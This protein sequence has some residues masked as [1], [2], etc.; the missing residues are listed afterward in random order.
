MRERDVGRKCA[1]G[2]DIHVYNKKYKNL[3][4]KSL[5]FILYNISILTCRPWQNRSQCSQSRSELAKNGSGTINAFH[6][7]GGGGGWWCMCVCVC[8]CLL[9]AGR[10]WGEG[11]KVGREE[12]EKEGEVGEM[13]EHH[14]VFCCVYVGM[15]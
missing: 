4:L 2:V 3:L 10:R 5:E 8:V 11:E 13:S 9:V 6:G 12:E 15:Y 1:R 14:R 7:G